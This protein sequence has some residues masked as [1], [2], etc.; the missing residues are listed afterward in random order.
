MVIKPT[1]GYLLI[2]PL[3]AE[4]KTKGGIYLPETKSET[5]QEGHIIAKGADIKNFEIGDLVYYK[6]WG[7]NEIK[8]DNIDYIF[9]KIEDILAREYEK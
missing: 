6:K 1:N 8:L 9:V 2:K 4:V 5:P 7:G 3:E